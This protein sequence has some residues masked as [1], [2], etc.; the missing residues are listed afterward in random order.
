M[1]IA[2]ARPD[3]TLRRMRESDLPDLV[4]GANNPRVATNLRDAFPSPYTEADAREFLARQTPEGIPVNLVI[5]RNDRLV[6]L[7]GLHPQ[8]DVYRFGYELGYWVREDQWGSGIATAAI[9]AVVP[10]FFANSKAHRIFASVFV[11]N[12][13]SARVLEKAGFIQ[14]GVSRESVF[15]MGQFWDEVRYGLLRTDGEEE[16]DQ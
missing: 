6:G 12:P 1:L 5:A 16:V 13:A 8:A 14:E 11:F 3:L 2:T 9:Q 15:K 10:W 4:D 7:L